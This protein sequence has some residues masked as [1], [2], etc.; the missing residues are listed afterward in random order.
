M[1][2]E[3]STPDLRLYL[4]ERGPDDDPPPTPEPPQ[5]RFYKLVFRLVFFYLVH[6]VL[7]RD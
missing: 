1:G 5:Q 7:N 4:K 3:D 6:L 2:D